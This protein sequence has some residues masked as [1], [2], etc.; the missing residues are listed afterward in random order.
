MKTLNEF[1]KELEGSEEL[2]KELG[3]IENEEA[4][5]EF[6]RKNECEASVEE[7]LGG[8]TGEISE[9]ASGE[10]SDDEAENVAG[11][12][13]QTGGPLGNFLSQIAIFTPFISNFLPGG[14]NA[15]KAEKTVLKGEKKATGVVTPAVLR[16]TDTS[17]TIKYYC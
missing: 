1:Y 14:K 11:G 7:F 10:I 16:T 17:T 8:L 6:I 2:L 13:R 15:I 5:A 12:R 9:E 4:L 3:A